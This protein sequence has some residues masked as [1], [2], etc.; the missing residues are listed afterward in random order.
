MYGLLFENLYLVM[1]DDVGEV[2]L[3]KLVISISCFPAH[4]MGAPIL[5]P[6]AGETDPLQIAQKELSYSKIPFI[7]R[8]HLPCGMQPS[9]KVYTFSICIIVHPFLAR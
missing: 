6:L 2:A 1:Q 4:S 8:R 3:C 9:P 7:I 5:V